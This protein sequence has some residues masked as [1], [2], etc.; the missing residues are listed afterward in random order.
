[1]KKILTTI[2]FALIFAGNS[3]AA[4]T[5]NCKSANYAIKVSDI[6]DFSFSEF[7]VNGKTN[8]DAD[9]ELENSYLSDRIIAV[10]LKVDGVSKKIELSVSKDKKGKL[11]GNLYVGKVSQKAVCT[12]E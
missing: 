12:R 2:A 1:M 10:A 6:E 7:S 11:V 3:F 8:N 9:V 5:L 4:T